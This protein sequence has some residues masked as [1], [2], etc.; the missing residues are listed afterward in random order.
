MLSKIEFCKKILKV[1]INEICSEDLN[2]FNCNI[3]KDHCGVQLELS[4]FNTSKKLHNNLSIYVTLNDN[5]VFCE[6][7]V[8]QSLEKIQ[9]RFTLV[10][11]ATWRYKRSLMPATIS[12]K[13]HYIS[14][15]KIEFSL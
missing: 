13:T 4:S 15:Q 2:H 6:K 9:S 12:I 8:K 14:N 11:H 1:V 3:N 5:V 10:L 7:D